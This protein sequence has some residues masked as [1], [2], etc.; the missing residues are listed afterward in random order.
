MN[1]VI[2]PGLL[3]LAR[4]M[5]PGLMLGVLLLGL[6]G[7]GAAASP[8]PNEKPL[9]TVWEK[10]QVLNGVWKVRHGDSAVWAQAGYADAHWD[11]AILKNGLF[12]ELITNRDYA[13]YRHEIRLPPRPETGKL[14]GLLHPPAASQEF[15]W[16]GE[17]IGRTG[18]VGASKAEER[19]GD[20]SLTEIPERLSGP[21]RHVL[22]IR[23]SAHHPLL[24][25]NSIQ[26]TLGEFTAL[27]LGSTR[28]M[29][30]MFFLAGV[31]VFG[32]IYRF[33]N[34]RASGYGRNTVLFSVCVL[35]A[36]G[37][38]VF[39]HLGFVADL[40]AGRQLA[41]RL[42]L[43]VSWY[44]MISMV[45]DYFIFAESF[46]YRWLL[47][48]LL[49]GGL[50]VAAPM[51][52]AYTGYAPLP[53]MGAIFYANQIFVYLSMSASL[54]VIGWA[55]WRKQ[56][57]SGVALLGILSMMAGITVTWMFQIEWAWAAGIAAHVIFLARAQS[58]QMSERIRR[59]Q[60]MDLHSARLEIEL[61][62]K[63]IQPHFLLN[64]LNSIIAW[65]EEEPKT[66]AKL[67]NAL[68]D[69]L[70]MLLRISSLKTI[71]LEEEIRLCRIHLQVMGL[72]QDKTYSLEHTGVMGDERIP[73]MV[74]HTLVENG[75]THGYV[76]KSNGTFLLRRE[77]F[78]ES[79]RYS[80]F[81]DGVPREKKEKKAEG[82]GLRYVRTR[83]EEVFPG[84]W[85]LES[86][87]VENGWEV[88][89][90]IKRENK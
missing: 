72:R 71:S 41:V 54:W 13:W 4:E 6:A 3:R 83:L 30:V 63:N 78:P 70:G 23:T 87:S 77:D 51:G 27:H 14:L 84:R 79:V 19:A 61:L 2:F 52:L 66:A 15:Y 40:D 76:G 57:G 62:K 55:V 67:V 10:P 22:A 36:A 32:A 60:E 16:D 53:W 82:T 69:E 85:R 46:P 18:R 38:I 48:V 65:L 9:L 45:P 17:L 47:P 74:L 88:T 21:G 37:Y 68:A 8:S 31:F 28:E 75:L 58:H 56:T 86:R 5:T 42:A 73:P 34:Y 39:K 64:S 20:I 49:I 33:L 43:S 90:D 59:H 1:S 7:R 89:L 35:S 81:N 24:F 50:F 80:L 29:L 44:F 26:L 12:R 11:S 25:P